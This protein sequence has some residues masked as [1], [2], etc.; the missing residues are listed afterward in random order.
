MAN[1]AND[2]VCNLLKYAFNIEPL[3]PCLKGL[4]EMDF[5]AGEL[6]ITFTKVIAATDLVYTPQWSDDL[7][8]WSDSGITQ[9]T[10]S[11][12]G[13]IRRIRA[14]ISATAGE[15]RFL[16]VVVTKQ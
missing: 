2:G 9:Q 12:D 10:V 6:S 1:P 15:P 7:V 5:E 14:S 3:E 8:D 11:D 4:P 16:R 13:T